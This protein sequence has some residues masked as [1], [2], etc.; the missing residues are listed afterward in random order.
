MA[1]TLDCKTVIFFAHAGDRQYANARRSGASVKTAREKL[2]GETL[3]YTTVRQAYIKFVQN[4][5]FVQQ[6]EIPIGLILT[7]AVIKCHS[8]LIKNI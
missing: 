8:H 7:P 4:F 6:R 1:F 3:K 5:P 2:W